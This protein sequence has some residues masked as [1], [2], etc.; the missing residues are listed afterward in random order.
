M[1]S[2]STEIVP[3]NEFEIEVSKRTAKLLY[4]SDKSSSPFSSGIGISL[5]ISLIDGKVNV[6]NVPTVDPS[7]IYLD[8]PIQKPSDPEDIPRPNYYPSYSGLNPLQ[9][10][11][12][13]NWLRDISK[14]INIGY[15]FIYY[16]G[17]ERQLLLGDFDLAFD[18]I[19]F[20]QNYH[21]NHSFLSYSNSALPYA[22]LLRKRKDKLEQLYQLRPKTTIENFDLLLIHSL[23]YDLSA[24]NILDVSKNISGINKRFIISDPET[25]E[26]ALTDCLKARYN[27]PFFPFASRFPIDVLLRRQEIIFANISFPPEI[28]TPDIPNY[29]IGS[30]FTREVRELISEAHE[31][32][33]LLRKEKRKT[34]I[35]S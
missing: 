1:I 7:T 23:G 28:R 34:K 29:L 14:P 24:R 4:I 12:Y 35:N 9:R 19:L 16:Y 10:W 22:C 6:S 26:K 2:T 11:L 33:K 13:L 20:L 32:T 15:V 18:E 5:N 25:F 8:L 3:I 31:K 17:L 30:P 21:N 27:F